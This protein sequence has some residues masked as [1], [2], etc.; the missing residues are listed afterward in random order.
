MDFRHFTISA[1]IVM[2]VVTAVVTVEVTASENTFF[3]FRKIDNSFSCEIV[4]A[5]IVACH[6]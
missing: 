3:P 5:E 1:P 6:G 2:A 4:C